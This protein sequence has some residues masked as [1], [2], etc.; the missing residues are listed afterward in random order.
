[1]AVRARAAALALLLIASVTA[2]VAR[3]RGEDASDPAVRLQALLDDRV[4]REPGVRSG[5]LLVDGPG[6]HWKGA[7]GIAFA[8][9]AIPIRPDDQFNI[10]S[11]AKMMTACIVMKLVEGGR[12]GLDDRICAYLPDSLVSGL[13]VLAGRSYGE[14]ITVRQLLNHTSGIADDWSCPGFVDS[15]A[16][17]P[18]RR[19]RPEETI[20]YVKKHCPPRFPPGA[21]FQYSDPGYNLLG[22]ILERVTG[23]PLQR[24]YR[25]DL[26]DPLGM[27]HTYRPAYEPARPSIPGRPPGER[28]LD[29]LECGLWTS[30]MTADWAGGGLVSTT[31]DLCVFLRSFAE[32]RIFRNPSTRDSMLTWVESGPINNYGLG[33]SRVLFRRLDEPAAAELGEV[34]GHSGSSHNFMY[35]WPQEDVI[36][37]GTLNQMAVETDLYDTVR[38]ILETV[39]SGRNSPHVR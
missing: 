33:V 29:D 3:A 6:V 11:I 10:D 37:V 18:E 4:E 21:G 12:L 39:R 27:D 30:V 9:S 23:R 15:V 22:L 5:L 16:A 36:I 20:E 25:D 26:L 17:H 13:H 8:D 32:N 38:D 34:W 35:Y 28:Y 2:S 14:A 24:L 31:E 19:W 7:S 1:M